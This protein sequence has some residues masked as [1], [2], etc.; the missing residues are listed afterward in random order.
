MLPASIFLA[1]ASVFL[2]NKG[3][4]GLPHACD[5]KLFLF[6]VHSSSEEKGTHTLNGLYTK[7]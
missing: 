1:W 7:F 4:S 5:S 2:T 6:L 3:T